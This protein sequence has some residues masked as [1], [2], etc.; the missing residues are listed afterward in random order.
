MFFNMFEI[1]EGLFFCCIYNCCRYY[2]RNGC[3]VAAGGKKAVR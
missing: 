2:C 3:N 1:M